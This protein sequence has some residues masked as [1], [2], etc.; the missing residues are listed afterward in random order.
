MSSTQVLEE[1]RADTPLVVRTTDVRVTPLRFYVVGVFSAMSF[2]QG[3][4]WFTFN[5]VPGP[6]REYYGGNLSTFELDLLLNWGSIVFVVFLPV[7]AWIA[8]LPRGVRLAVL[9]GAT[10]ITVGCGVR[11]VPSLVPGAAGVSFR[12]SVVGRCF[13][14]AGQIIIAVS[15]PLVFASPSRVSLEWFAEDERVTSTTTIIIMSTLSTAVGYVVGPLLAPDAAHVPRLLFVEF[16][17][18]VPLVVLA[19][20]YLPPHPVCPPSAVAAIK[21]F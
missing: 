1:V 2:L 20:A 5:S 4:A 7:A 3:L 8:T 17:L 18:S 21:R 11:A 10:A 15:G 19:Y 12:S 13:L 6:T 9:I 16:G 14:H